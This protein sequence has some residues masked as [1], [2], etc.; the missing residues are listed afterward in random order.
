M[1]Y[2]PIDLSQLPA[3]AVVE[4]LDFEEIRSAMLA[5]L[6]ERHPDFD[7]LDLESDPAVKVLE[8]AAYREIQVRQR[9]NDA[10]RAVMIA[11]ATGS[12]LD[13]LVAWW[14]IERQD[15]EDDASLRARAQLAPEGLS[16]AGPVGAYDFHARGADGRVADVAVLSP[17]PGV[18]RV[19]VLSTEAAGVP[20]QDILDA[21]ATALNDER[22]RPLCDTVQVDPAAVLD[23]AITATLTVRDGPD[24]EVVRA[25]AEQAARDY[26]ADRHALGKRVSLSGIYAVLHVAGVD[27]VALDSPAEDVVAEADQAPHATSVTVEVADG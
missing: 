1:S 12:D 23:Y 24:P 13:Q 20:A 7:T 27:R 2:T 11:Y 14:N 22:V 19:V 25:T 10:A 9:V 16:V 5:D 21:V 6:Q 26:A 8:A 18:V 15:G 17:S 4:D 3:P